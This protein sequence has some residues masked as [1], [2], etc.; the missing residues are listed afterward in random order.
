MKID[1]SHR[2]LTAFNP[3]CLLIAAQRY[4]Q[5]RRTIAAASFARELAEAWPTIPAH[6][7]NIIKRDLSDAFKNDD[8]AR[9]RGETYRPLGMDCDRQA[10]EMVRQAWQREGDTS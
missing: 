3:H 7:R 4:Y 6:T 1:Q 5:G 2:H 10:W 9:A 8:K